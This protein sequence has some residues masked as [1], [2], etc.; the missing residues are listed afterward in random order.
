VE[1]TVGPSRITIFPPP[2]PRTTSSPAMNAIAP[3]L[4]STMSV[5]G[6]P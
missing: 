3:S 6:E 1:S 2:V 5:V 4:R